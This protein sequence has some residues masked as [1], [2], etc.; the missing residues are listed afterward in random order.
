MGA[1]TLVWHNNSDTI[2]YRLKNLDTGKEDIT[3]CHICK[4]CAVS[5][6]AHKKI[7]SSTFLLTC[8]RWMHRYCHF[9]PQLQPCTNITSFMLTKFDGLGGIYAGPRPCNISSLPYMI[10][11]V[12]FHAPSIC[13]TSV[14]TSRIRKN[15]VGCQGNYQL[16]SKG[17]VAIS[18]LYLLAC[19]H[20]LQSSKCCQPQHS[21][22]F[23]EKT[24]SS[25]TICS[26]SAI[27]NLPMHTVLG[28]SYLWASQELELS[29]WIIHFWCC[30]WIRPVVRDKIL[31][32]HAIL[33][34][35][36]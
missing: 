35:S 32:F 4:C 18:K 22:Q 10:K 29:I 8:A 5:E 24:L 7:V 28:Y 14:F 34:Q 2:I 21:R 11:L 1:P 25:S 31:L 19:L 17:P 23:L 20:L 9:C 13:I 36:A 3:Q 6:L 15:I 26:E 27:S 30:T 12:L 16:S 33:V